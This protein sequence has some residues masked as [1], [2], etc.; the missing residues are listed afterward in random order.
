MAPVATYRLQ[1]HGG[2]T[3]DDARAVV[4][5]LDAL[6]ITH[7]HSSPLLAARAGSEHGY[8][9]TDPT[10]VNPAVGGEPALA[11]LAAD[12]A[13]RRMGLVLDIVPN[14]MAASAENPFW[15]DVLANGPA[16]PYAR[17]FD[18]AWREGEGTAP[19]RVLLPVL[20]DARARVLERGELCLRLAGGRF[21]I[22]Y[23]EH[24][25]PTDPNTTAP[26]VERAADL[27]APAPA[28][29][30]RAVA[31]ELRD[32]PRRL[33]R[34][35]DDRARRV[36]ESTGIAERLSALAAA[37]RATERAL[38]AAAAEWSGGPAGRIRMRRLLDAQPY[39]LVH[40]RRAEREINYRRFFDV[41]DL[42][43]LHAEDPEVFAATHAL[44]L[45]WLGRG[46]VG[47]FRIDHPD[48]L[49]DPAAYLRR[50]FESAA[51]R[52]PGKEPSLWVE[53]ILAPGER[54]RTEWPVSGT[55]GYDFMNACE[56]AF[57]DAHGFES[58]LPDY[59][60]IVRSAAGFA[61]SALAGKRAVLES[62]LAA[63][64]RQLAVRIRR[65][66]EAAGRPAL[67]TRHALA[68]AIVE[69]IAALPVYRTYV[70]P[71]APR[72]AGDDRALLADALSSARE[73]GHAASAALDLLASVLLA[74][75]RVLRT[76]AIEQRRLRAVQRFQQLSGPA[77]AKGV[78][79]TAFYAYV[80]LL[81]LN[82][83][84]GGP[85]GLKGSDAVGG[86]HAAQRERAA[87]WPQALLTLTTHDT[88]RSSDVRARL[89]V[90]SELPAEWE[91][92]FYRCRRL[93]RPFGRTVHGRQAP[94]ANTTW[95]FFQALVGVWPPDHSAPGAP[96]PDEG[97][98]AE[99]RDRLSAYMLKAV[100]EAKQRTTWV[101]PDAEF[102]EA[103]AGY[104]DAVLDPVR[105]ARVL[106]EAARFAGTIGRAGLWASL[107]RSLL[108]LTSPGVPD[109][110]QGDEL[111]NFTLVDPDNRRPVDF[112]RRAAALA[113]MPGLADRPGL[114]GFVRDAI[115]AP[116]DGRIKLHIVRAALAARRNVPALR[117]RGT[118]LPLA[119]AGVRAKSV[120]A[121]SR[122]VAE[123]RAVVVVPRLCA[124]ESG[125]GAPAGDFWAGTFLHGLPGAH[126][127]CALTGRRV[128]TPGG[129]ASLTDLLPELP[130]ALLVADG[131]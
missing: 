110:Y 75:D 24:S 78:E 115:G 102:E 80:P 98:L 5:Y 49:L 129:H 48:G 69:T 15:E 22:A 18:I 79:D 82:E 7:I 40:W 4:P 120:L 108:H 35:A 114:A 1:M 70:D 116:E 20:G 26:V 3:L 57:T 6:G 47:G 21:R 11:A 99:L 53:K 30:L 55:T 56:R 88:K 33:A 51:A 119:A 17:W 12:L 19:G 50:L 9:V 101:D 126:W 29:E 103:V 37:S 36:A 68:T 130:L 83:V 45:A 46:W 104:V 121:F 113:R 84:G 127:T 100:R 58:L 111:W 8:D 62:G 117:E 31:R 63:G 67:P 71:A 91:A 86:F 89:A 128:E 97:R 85:E 90:I 105:G 34:P 52:R 61:A 73:R 65:L 14:H 77:A 54:L 38:E 125:T 109:L 27:L 76:P 16:S 106:A 66:A 32:L 42:V 74:D 41:N 123:S 92:C 23:F 2:F 60:R 28:D 25:W 93:A 39:R 107:A 112:A 96:L 10:R 94:D 43:A 44:P 72:P 124:R 13:A 118:Y 95:L 81:S 122:T 59:Q 87:R 64:V 131:A